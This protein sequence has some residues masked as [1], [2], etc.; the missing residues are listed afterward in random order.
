MALP[1]PSV[2]LVNGSSR[3]MELMVP[4]GIM[5]F[6]IASHRIAAQLKHIKTRIHQ[7]E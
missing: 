7:P 6:V 4:A 1:H 5:S 2:S 3:K